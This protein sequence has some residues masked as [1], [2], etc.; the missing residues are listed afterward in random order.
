MI[1]FEKW[2]ETGM[3]SAAL[4]AVLINED[5]PGKMEETMSQNQ[6]SST[7][8]DADLVLTKAVSS[9]VLATE[10]LGKASANRGNSTSNG[11]PPRGLSRGQAAEYIGVSTALF[12][13]LVKTGQMPKP[14]RAQSRVIWDRRKVDE[15]F[16][17]L[18]TEQN[19]NPWN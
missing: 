14:N 6:S 17:D 11:W 3:Q 9:L 16:T 10:A 8:N 1:R 13:S 18:G 19:E 15:A 7:I 5:E 12:D 4:Q 2:T